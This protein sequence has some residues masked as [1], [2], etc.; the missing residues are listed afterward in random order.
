MVMFLKNIKELYDCDYDFLVK[1][2]KTNSKEVEK[3]D[4]F[5]CIKGVNEDRHNF[6]QEAIENGCSGLVVERGNNYSVPFI[7]VEN[8]NRELGRLAKKFYGYQDS[9]KIIGVTGTDGKT[10][11]SLCI[12]D[13][14]ND[15]GYIG[16]NGIK[17]ND[18]EVDTNNTTPELNLI[19]KYLSMFEEKKLKY[20]S[21][22]VS[23]EGLL[24]NRV[25]DV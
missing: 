20:A 24:H 1:D 23:S 25:H 16:T 5:V 14:L 13:M 22:E 10:T 21:M 8:T 19:Y 6:I 2:I 12:R 9:L 3:G 18:M 11:T 15:C 17:D 7:K 4:L